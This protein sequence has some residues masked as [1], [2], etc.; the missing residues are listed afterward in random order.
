[1]AAATGVPRAA[2]AETVVAAGTDALGPFAATD[3]AAYR[4]PG[5]AALPA[6]GAALRPGEWVSPSVATWRPGDP[7]AR[8]FSSLAVTPA[9]LAAP[10][11][12]APLTFAAGRVDLVVTGDRPAGRDLRRGRRVRRR[13]RLLR[14]RQRRRPGRGPRHP[15]A[16]TS[17]PTPTTAD[18][19]PA[20]VD[21][22]DVLL[23]FWAQGVT[24]VAVASALAVAGWLA[25]ALRQVVPPHGGVFIARV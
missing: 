5:G 1:V 24:V 23:A 7:A 12:A 3:A 22:L 15:P 21:P 18:H 11:V 19:L 13:D 25:A 2:A 20:Q 6:V 4:L 9:Q 17:R 8:P 16:R 14:R 10:G